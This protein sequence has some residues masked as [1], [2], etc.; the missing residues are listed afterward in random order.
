MRDFNAVCKF[1]FMLA[2]FVK[3]K[4]PNNGIN[5]NYGFLIIRLLTSFF[6][7]KTTRLDDFGII[8]L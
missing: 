4:M 2:S 7:L 1:M 6:Q 5:N 3:I 8:E